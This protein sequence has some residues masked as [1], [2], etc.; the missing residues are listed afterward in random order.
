MKCFRILLVGILGLLLEGCAVGPKYAKAPVP[1]PHPDTYKEL[2]GWK[3]AQPNDHAIKGKWWELFNDSELNSL[4]NEVTVSNQNLKIV[5][6]RFREA[7]A[8]VRYNR[9]FEFPTL[10][11]APTLVGE[12]RSQNAPYFPLIAPAITCYLLISPMRWM[13]GDMSEGR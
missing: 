5:E 7:R 1:M 10:T 9:S 11:V 4:E 8:L 2:D 6:A 3:T 12:R 13:C